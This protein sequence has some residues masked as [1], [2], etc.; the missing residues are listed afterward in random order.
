MR[1]RIVYEIGRRALGCAAAGLAALGAA[2]GE[3]GGNAGDWPRFLGPSLDGHAPDSGLA[4]A[5]TGAV[6]R[7]A[8][9][10]RAP[11]AAGYGGPAISGGEVFI[12]D[13]PGSGKMALRCLDLAAGREL[14][15]FEYAAQGK[16]APPGPRS[17]PTV[18]AD[19]I[20]IVDQSGIAQ[21]VDR[22]ARAGIWKRDLL[23]GFGAS[24]LF[25]GVSHS[26]LLHE[27]RLIV[28]PQGERAG[29]AALDPESGRD[30]WRSPKLPS[31]NVA[32]Y[33]GSYVTPAIARL[34]GE[35]QAIVVTASVGDADGAIA[36]KGCVAGISLADGAV[37]WTYEGWQ[38]PIP[39][40]TPT[41]LPGDRVFV[42]AAY[43]AGSALIRVL[44]RDGQWSVEE[45]F[46]TKECGSQI[47]QALFHRDH[48][49][50]VSNGKERKEGLMCLGLDGNVKWHTTNSEFCSKA[51]PGLPNLGV[52]NAILVGDRLL[53]MNG[54]EGR[55]HVVAAD[56]EG[57]RELA[58]TEAFLE[59]KE[60]YSPMAVSGNLVLARD[61][62]QLV[63]VELAP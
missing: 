50:A 22:R 42:T 60:L 56:P 30:I 2:R 41:L 28:A 57:F 6:V 21:G 38:C 36:I 51:K 39:I 9:R 24:N 55:L 11:L 29:L 45:L 18:T 13:E 26:P 4:H 23:E 5:R 43:K 15:R 17:T 63:C 33:C 61:Q 46:R 27:G 53:I 10:W 37:R 35:N 32:G 52:G 25:W 1:S 8:V 16:V 59:G 49:F 62:K 7:A 12:L 3:S 14:W 44:R 47:Q 54:D 31:M 48:I 19:R 40:A 58:R 34:G 20:Y